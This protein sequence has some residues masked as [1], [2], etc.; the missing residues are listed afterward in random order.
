MKLFSG[1]DPSE[2]K[3]AI[4][5]QVKE[6]NADS[7]SVIFHEWHSHKAKVW[8]KGYA[9]EMKSM[10]EDDILPLIGHMKMEEVEPM[11]SASGYKE[12]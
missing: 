12:I 4:K 11:A 10:F 9:D 5:K 7:F 3:Q 6:E 2:Q 8:S 1:V